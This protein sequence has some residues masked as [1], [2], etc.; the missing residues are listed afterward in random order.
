MFHEI[1]QQMFEQERLHTYVLITGEYLVDD[2]VHIGYGIS[3][4]STATIEADIKTVFQDISADENSVADLIRNCNL[5]ELDPI[6]LQD[7]VEDF[8]AKVEGAPDRCILTSVGSIL[9]K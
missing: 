4:K 1:S 2:Q 3:V 5:Y 9:F 7:I 6:H 8:L